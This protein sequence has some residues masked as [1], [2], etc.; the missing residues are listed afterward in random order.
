MRVPELTIPPSR[1]LR[2]LILQPDL[3]IEFFKSLDGSRVYECK[4]LPADAEVRSC[5]WDV[6]YQRFLIAIHSEDFPETRPGMVLEMFDLEFSWHTAAVEVVAS[7]MT[8]GK[9][10]T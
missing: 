5:H 3:L 7:R 9:D 6:Q 2:L 8:V 10:R 4:G 1:R